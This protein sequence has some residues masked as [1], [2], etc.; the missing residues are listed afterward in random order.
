MLTVSNSSL[1]QRETA[2]AEIGMGFLEETALMEKRGDE[3]RL[4]GRRRWDWGG[5][6]RS[7]ARISAEGH[8]AA[9]D[10]ILGGGF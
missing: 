5:D 6:G 8:S 7:G 1:L 10:S 2:F 9:V 3:R 4:R